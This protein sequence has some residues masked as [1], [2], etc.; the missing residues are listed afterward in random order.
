MSSDCL[1]SLVQRSVSAVRNAARGNSVN[2]ATGGEP[3]DGSG[4]TYT[5]SVLPES[6]RVS[7]VPRLTTRPN[8]A[9]ASTATATDR[10]AEIKAD[11]PGK[12]G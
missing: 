7:R 6:T 9:A 4:A 3:G 5:F 2:E 1:L 8:T 12:W 10:R 11:G